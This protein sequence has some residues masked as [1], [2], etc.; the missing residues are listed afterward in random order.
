MKRILCVLTCLVFLTS[1]G[2]DKISVEPVS[3]NFKCEA[4]ISFGGNSYVCFM[5]VDGEHNAVYEMTEPTGVKG[6]TVSTGPDGGEAEFSGIKYKLNDKSPFILIIKMLSTLENGK[7]SEINKKELTVDG[8]IGNT[9]YS[10]K[11]MPDGCPVCAEIGSEITVD[12]LS[13]EIL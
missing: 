12:F 1:C 10:L 4:H 13:L 8:E 2:A 7:I 5:S 11:I 3:K 9:E 6:I